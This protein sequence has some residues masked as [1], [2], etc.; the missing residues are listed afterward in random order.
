MPDIGTVHIDQAM[1]NLSVA[2]MNDSFV[3]DQVMPPLPVAKRSDKYF[4]YDQAAFLQTS[5]LDANGL[6]KSLRRPKTEAAEID[7][8][9]STDQYYGEEY[10]RRELVTDAERKLAD[11]P[12]QPDID[13][14][15]VVT[16][17]LQMDNEIMVARRACTSTAYSPNNK[18]LLTGGATGTSWAQYGSANSL[19]LSDIRNG[20]VTVRK[21]LLREPNTMTLTVDSAQVLADHPTIK[22]LV[23]YTHQDA[24]T[25]SGLPKVLRGLNTVEAVT[26]KST[27]A[28]GLA[29]SSGNVWTD[30]NG[31]N[32]ALIYFRSVDTGPRSI[33]FGRTFDIP[34]DTTGVRGISIRRYRWDPKK[35]EYMEGAMTR[36]WKIIAKDGNGLAVGGYLI[37]GPT[38]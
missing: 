18:V 15:T 20:K 9:L 29:F 36:D 24:L 30:E 2:I 33:H 21:A 3:A 26:Q 35:G 22:D 23:K 16:N 13:A 37:S 32:I 14:T 7:Y 12:L 27:N 25:S 38:L 10:A 11:N 34:D 28:E 5:G 19:P 31:L 8:A 17:A 4:V 6:P 1:T